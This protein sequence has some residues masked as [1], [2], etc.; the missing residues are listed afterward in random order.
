MKNYFQRLTIFLE[1]F[2]QDSI[3]FKKDM[4]ALDT[5]N[6]ML[7]EILDVYLNQ[8]CKA[9][10]LTKL[11]KDFFRVNKQVSSLSTTAKNIV[12][13]GDEIEKNRTKIAS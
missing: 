9:E 7:G 5:N 4:I 10:Y 13:E 3:V 1:Q 2:D 12:V 11:S 6:K 8:L